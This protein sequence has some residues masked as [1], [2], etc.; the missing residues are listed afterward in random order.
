[1][2][3]ALQKQFPLAFLALFLSGLLPYLLLWRYLDAPNFITHMMTALMFT[4]GFAAERGSAPRAALDALQWGAILLACGLVSLRI[5]DPLPELLYPPVDLVLASFVLLAGCGFAIAHI[6]L[7][8]ERAA[9]WIALMLILAVFAVT[10]NLPSNLLEVTFSA[11]LGIVLAG[12]A[13]F[14]WQRQAMPR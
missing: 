4:A 2:I 7:R 6:A 5:L 14:R 10:N 9:R 1:M 12:A 11:G 13:W 3:A 8:A